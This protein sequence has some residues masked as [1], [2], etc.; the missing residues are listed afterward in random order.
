MQFI[1][2]QIFSFHVK[3]KNKPK[4][5]VFVRAL[6]AVVKSMKPQRLPI[7]KTVTSVFL[8]FK[9]PQVNNALFSPLS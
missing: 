8:F 1:S 4:N 6:F 7:S 3:K 2:R 9:I 5:M